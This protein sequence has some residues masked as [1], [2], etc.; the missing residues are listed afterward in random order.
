[1]KEF[2]ENFISFRASRFRYFSQG[3]GGHLLFAFH[4]YG[5]SAESFAFLAETLPPGMTL[6]AIDLPFHGGTEWREKSL[7]L[8]PADLLGL[9]GEIAASLADRSGKWS[10]FGYSMGGRIALQLL[11]LAP[12][13]ID[14]M[15]LRAPDGLKVNP[16]YRLATRTAYGNRLFRHTMRRPGWF[17]FLLRAANTLALVNPSFYKFTFHYV[18]DDPARQELYRRWTVLRAFRPSFDRLAAIIRERR[19]PIHLVYGDY[20]R[21]IHWQRGE[22]FRRIAGESCRLTRLPSGHRLLQPEFTAIIVS[23]LYLPIV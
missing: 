15:V 4:G 5:E 6:V 7:L 21:I 19:L 17:F 9:L 8:E 12:E 23:T 14:R 22:R 11:Q 10:L 13:R 2:R 18:E 16:W 20:D 3:A 1:M